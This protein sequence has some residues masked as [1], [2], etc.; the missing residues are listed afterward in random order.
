M[1]RLLQLR[2]KLYCGIYLNNWILAAW[3]LKG[4][5]DIRSKKKCLWSKESFVNSKT[6]SFIKRNRFVCINEHCFESSKLSS[7]QRNL[8]FDRIS[9]KCFFY[10]KKCFFDSQKCFFDSNKLF[11]GS[12]I[13]I[14]SKKYRQWVNKTQTIY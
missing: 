8:F 7:I 13:Y 6:F 11:S 10:S 9:K 5:F 14:L 1:C 4:F 2:Y 3:T 12:R